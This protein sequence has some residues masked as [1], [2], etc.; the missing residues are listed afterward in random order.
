MHTNKKSSF[1]PYLSVVT[2]AILTISTNSNGMD[3][4]IKTFEKAIK[5][6][7]KT[8]DKTVV[9]SV[10]GSYYPTEEDKEKIPWDIVEDKARHCH[11]ECFKHRIDFGVH[12]IGPVGILSGCGLR[13][14]HYLWSCLNQQDSYLKTIPL[15]IGAVVLTGASVCGLGYSSAGIWLAIQGTDYAYIP[16]MFPD[17][18]TRPIM[19]YINENKKKVQV[20]TK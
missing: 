17:K 2:I 8:H 4:S 1:L 9:E 6:A 11:P 19:S 12:L 14:S 18:K 13:A 5:R 10:I 7:I 3:S 16:R 20:R 15:A